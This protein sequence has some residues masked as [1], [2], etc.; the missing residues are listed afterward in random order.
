MKKN[1]SIAIFSM[2]PVPYTSPLYNELYRIQKKNIVYYLDKLGIK[3]QYN[4]YFQEKTNNDDYIISHHKHKFLS[5]LSK[6]N[7]TGFFSRIN[8]SVIYYTLFNKNEYILINGYQTF[9]SWLIWT[10]SYLSRKK[11]IFKGETINTNKNL[12]K[13]IIIKVFLSRASIV[14]YSCA[15]NFKF[16]QF[17]G[18]NKSKLFSC[19]SSVDYDYFEKLKSKPNYNIKKNFYKSLNIKK[20]DRIIIFVSKFIKRKNPIELIYA[21]SNLNLK[22]KV[23]FA[24]NGPLTGMITKNCKKNRIN[25][26]ITN[27]LDQE[28]LSYLYEL[29]DLYVNC[30][31]YDASP[32]TLN[33]AIF[34]NVPII[35]PNTNIGQSKDLIKEGLNGF[36]YE[37]GNIFDLSQKIQSGLKLNRNK[38]LIINNKIVNDTHPKKSALRLMRKL[39]D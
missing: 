1:K 17:I 13:K 6:K 19:P 16:Y 18:I 5:N 33:E 8:L 20:D 10:V 21:L 24:G 37:Q 31:T 7:I 29:A 2:H 34:Y 38:S 4:P 35:C 22:F 32:K 36:T 11:V 9:T 3:S 15:G 39:N 28:R 26:K 12:L 25:H 30:S 14:L 27:F 23:I